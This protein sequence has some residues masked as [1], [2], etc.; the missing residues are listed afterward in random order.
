MS[1]KVFFIE[2]AHPFSR[3]LSDEFSKTVFALRFKEILS[4]LLAEYFFPYICKGTLPSSNKTPR[5]GVCVCTLSKSLQNLICRVSTGLTLGSFR[6][7][8]KSD[9][10]KSMGLTSES[11]RWIVVNMCFR[12]RTPSLRLNAPKA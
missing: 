9:A 8:Q 10:Y 1:E 4:Q 6:H 7:P 3:E 2:L 5:V 11:N 12:K